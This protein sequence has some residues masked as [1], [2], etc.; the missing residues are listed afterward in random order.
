[1]LSIEFINHLLAYRSICQER[2]QT[3]QTYGK[4]YTH[5]FARTHIIVSNV[6]KNLQEAFKERNEGRILDIWVDLPPQIIN[7]FVNQHFDKMDNDLIK[8]D[9]AVKTTDKLAMSIRAMERLKNLTVSKPAA[10]IIQKIYQS[11]SPPAFF[12]ESKAPRKRKIKIFSDKTANQDVI[13]KR[14]VG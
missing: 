13:E 5:N 12:R 3:G 4:W 1:M 10:S 14:L 9:K 2:I 8:M 7:H 11:Q 6:E